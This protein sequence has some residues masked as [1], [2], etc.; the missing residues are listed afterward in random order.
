MKYQLVLQ[1]PVNS[2]NDEVLVRFED[3]LNAYLDALAT[4]E[5][6]RLR[7]I[8]IQRVHPDERACSRL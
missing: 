5:R 8:G 2:M 1:F 4:I 3:K 6:P 7:R